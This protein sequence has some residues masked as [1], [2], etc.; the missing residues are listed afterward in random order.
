MEK[1]PVDLLLLLV[2]QH[3]QFRLHLVMM[4]KQVFDY[5]LIDVL[6][7]LKLQVIWL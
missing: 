6:V 7:E 5:V 3:R 1:I 4:I 2:H